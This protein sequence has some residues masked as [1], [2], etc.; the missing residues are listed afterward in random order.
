MMK[1]A[2]VV[3]TTLNR[4]E[5]FIRLIESLKKNTWAQYTDVYVGLDYPKIDIHYDGYKII[6]EYLSSPFPE[7]KS[8]NVI[9]RKTNYGSSMNMNALRDYV[10]TMYDRFIRMDDDLE[11][12]PNFLEYMNK[13][14]ER[15]ESDDNVI[16]ISGYSYPLDWNVNESSTLFKENFICPMWGT[17]FWR[18]KYKIIE[19]NIYNDRGLSEDAKLIIT[20]GG[21]QRMSDICRSEFADLCLSPEFDLT[22]ASRVS[23]VSLRMYMA[24]HDKSVIMPVVSKVRNWGFDGSGEYCAAASD[25]G[26]QMT[27]ENYPYH[28]QRIDENLSFTLIPDSADAIQLN[29]DIMNKFDPISFAAK[30]KMFIK[31]V[32]FVLVG[33]SMYAK[34][35]HLIRKFKNN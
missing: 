30:M 28:L 15:Y 23:D 18:D 14:L 32:L 8:L 19:K 24:V 31:L 2:P 11:L 21:L 17:A 3:V 34:I 16:A 10:L 29:K 4:H 27:A 6:D 25:Q 20:K 22:L 5:H 1:C 13:C 35:T 9:K 7:F 33:K 12:S 26:I